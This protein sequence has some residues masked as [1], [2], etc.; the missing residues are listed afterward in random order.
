MQQLPNALIEQVRRGEAIL[1]LG[2]G[3]SI[4]ALHSKGKKAPKGQELAEL[5]ATEFLGKEYIS[6]SL[7]EV[8]ELAISE[9]DLFTVQNYIANIFMDFYPN[10]FH[11]LIPLFSWISIFTTNYDLIIERAYEKIKDR[12]QELSVFKKDGEQI[13]A[14]L[15]MPKSVAYFKL[16]GCITHINDIELPLILTPDQYIT[17][18]KHRRLLFSRLYNYAVE[19]PIIFIG[20]SLADQDIRSMLVELDDLGPTKP[21]SYIV[22]PTIT[23]AEERLWSSRKITP[24]IARFSEFITALD[25]SIPR[26]FRGINTLIEPISHPIERHFKVTTGILRDSIDVLLSRDVDYIHTG[27]PIA[28]I[29]PKEF[30]KGSF[31][32]FAPVVNNLD[33]RRPH[34]DNILSEIVLAEESEKTKVELILV[35]GHAGSGKSILL[36]RICWEAAVEYDKICLFIKANSYIQYENI[37]EISRVCNERIFLFIEPAS[38]YK[39]QIE[40]IIYR[41][42]KDKIPIT[43]ITADRYNEWN[44]QCSSL[45]AYVSNTYELKYLIPFEIKTLIQLLG[46]N[47]SLGHLQ[48]LSLESQEDELSQKA[49]R[50]L[51]VALHEATLGKRFSEIV[52][53]EFN[54][55]SS[56]KA[57]TLYLTVCILHRLGVQT[58]AGLISRVHKI[59]FTEFREELFKPLEFIVFATEDKLIHDYYYRSRH[60]HIAEMVFEGVLVNPQ[61][62]FDEY[63]RILNNLDTDYISD[64]DALKGLSNAKELMRLFT[65]P[66]MIRQFYETAKKISPENP[67]LLQQEAIFEKN[68]VNGNLKKA[69]ELLKLAHEMAPYNKAINHSLAEL[70]LENA[71]RSVNPLEKRK[72]L[73]ET[74]KIMYEQNAGSIDSYRYHTLIKASFEELKDCQDEGDERSIST[75]IKNLEELIS[76]A[77]QIFPED[78][79][80]LE[81]EAKYARFCNDNPKSIS[82]LTEAFRSN[83]RSPYIAIR[84]SKIL[85]RDGREKD[86]I[87]VLKECVELNPADKD[88]NFWL[89]ITLMNSVE[90]VQADI[91]YYLRRSFTE[92]DSNYAAQFWYGRCLFIER[93]F[94]ESKEIFRSLSEARID[95]RVKREPRGIIINEEGKNKKYSGILT[96]KEYS[97]GFIMCDGIHELVYCNRLHSIHYIWDKLRANQRVIF[98]LGFNYMGPI[99]ISITSEN[100]TI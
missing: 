66:T 46:K 21:R 75:S 22:S 44:D 33:V 55:I 62:R 3:A 74:K 7:A 47:N 80:I 53:D 86:A 87:E 40:E 24:I 13:E 28:S 97:Y 91:K 54:S 19:Y 4:D 18:K 76:R 51:L 50:Q 17:H 72:Y 49:G 43:I 92:G 58:R 65:D 85:K 32:D 5:I 35:K 90:P 8:S 27:M 78:P 41:S 83:K 61:S 64:S 95:I 42:N 48:G 20:Q 30:Y 52:L 57:K 29:D 6:R 63:M 16:H 12:K 73:E 81:V 68:R 67:S 15:R 36:M 69:E 77:H 9:T 11:E 14:K 89:A 56:E 59:P 71:K 34:V 23:P 39:D 45:E 99:A 25:E 38:E 37:R 26:D 10:T 82:L 60:Q 31:F 88:I 100:N 2:S 1:F 94:L 79:F 70:A 84:L 98:E 96:K 93:D